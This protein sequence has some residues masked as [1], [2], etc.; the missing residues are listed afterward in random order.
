MQTKNSIINIKNLITNNAN[1][2]KLLRN[3]ILK[4]IQTT[5]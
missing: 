2:C 4:I 5:P 3:F 1:Q